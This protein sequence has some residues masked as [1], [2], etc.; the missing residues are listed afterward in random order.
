MG[1][2]LRKVDKQV[3]LLRLLEAEKAPGI[4]VEDAFSCL[5]H[6]SE[7]GTPFAGLFHRFLFLLFVVLTSEIGPLV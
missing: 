4:S 2:P 3:A 7:E 1:P 6:S 5:K